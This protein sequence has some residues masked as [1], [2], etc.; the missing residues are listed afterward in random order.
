M[1][2]PV[3]ATATN[4][5]SIAVPSCFPSNST[6]RNGSVIVYEL[7]FLPSCHIAPL[8]IKME[9][10]AVTPSIR[11]VRGQISAVLT[12]MFR[13][14]TQSTQVPRYYVKLCH[15]SSFPTRFNS[16]LTIYL[17]IRYFIDSLNKTWNDKNTYFGHFRFKSATLLGI[18]VSA[19]CSLQVVVNFSTVTYIYIYICTL[20]SCIT[21][22]FLYTLLRAKIFS[23]LQHFEAQWCL[24][25]P[26]S[27]T[28]NNSTICPQNEFICFL[29]FAQ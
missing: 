24:H 3:T 19:L 11:E 12:Q 23:Q 4:A 14:F 2:R 28:T 8:D 7:L 17:T 15:D 26:L 21:S 5:T 16:F 1:L 10:S 22:P 9:A 20:N 13:D 6:S 25:V 18:Q 29:R 27:L